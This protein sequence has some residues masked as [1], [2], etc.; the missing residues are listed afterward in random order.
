MRP[1]KLA[2]ALAVTLAAG[3]TPAEHAVTV[4]G[5]LELPAVPRAV[6]AAARTGV[7]DTEGTRTGSARLGGEA[8]EVLRVTPGVNEIVPVA[9]GH[10][11]R[12]VTPFASPRVRTVST[13]TT[14]VEGPAV[15]VAPAGEEPVALFLTDAGDETLALS[16]TLAPRR[17]P[18]RELRL[19]LEGAPAAARPAAARWEQAQPYVATLAVAL[20]GLALGEV[21]A[22][23]ALRRPRS[24]ERAGCAQPG[25]AVRLGQVLEGH[26]LWLL[27]GV[28]ENAAPEPVV[29]E[30]SLCE[31]SVGEAVLAVAA[32]SRVELAPGEAS[33]LYLAV[34][35][36]APAAPARARPLLLGHGGPR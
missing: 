35:P 1:I 9:V 3:T 26:G 10:L 27:V 28:V 12:R 24:G 14:Q 23:Y 5:G 30:E 19:V 16:L 33:E 20:R 32:W 34:R 25:L 22:G 6:L 36:Q 2:L 7:T 29:L 17:I 13:A 31:T 15:Y 21:P 8:P 11:N 18:P 4:G